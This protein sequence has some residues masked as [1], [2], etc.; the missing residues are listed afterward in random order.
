V[1]YLVLDEADAMLQMG[2][3]EDVE[4]LLHA[5]PPTRQTALFSA[6][7][8]SAI[9][10]L[11]ARYMRD[12]LTVA[13]DEARTVPQTTQRYYLLQ[14]SSK[15]AA[16]T[17]LLEAE[18]IK[19]ALIFTR[20][21]VGAAELAEAL[22]ARGYPAEALHGDLSQAARETVLGR[23]RT[24]RVTLLVST[25]VGARGL[26]IA[27]VSHVIN[28]DMPFDVTDYVHRIGRTGRAGRPGMALTLVTP[29]ERHRLRAIEMFTRQPLAR[30][31]LPSPAAAEAQ[32]DARFKRRLDAI[33]AESNLS[34][35]L[36]LVKEL[37][38]GTD[39]DVARIAAAA[40]RLAR[41]PEQHRP[42]TAVRDLSTSPGRTSPRRPQ[43]GGRTGRQPA[44][45]GDRRR[46]VQ[47]GAAVSAPEA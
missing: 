25:D 23:F 37:A 39:T 27:E 35:E 24:G 26:D 9:R 46:R 42:L 38:A 31:T 14:E 5:T 36:M 45:F 13:I 30:A 29:S 10:H 2:F 20:T 11:A 4:A 12:P 19:S 28:F 41:A 47:P 34:R 7:L 18:E 32:R 40:I 43:P 16:L 17:L 44:R 15:V 3:I 6:T 21:R 1:R 8:S 22:V 33:L